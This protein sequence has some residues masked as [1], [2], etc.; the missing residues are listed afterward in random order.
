[1][2]F[3]YR[4][5]EMDQSYPLEIESFSAK[6]RIVENKL[7]VAMEE[8][9]TE[10]KLDDRLGSPK[11]SIVGPTLG[12]ASYPVSDDETRSF[13]QKTNYIDCI[14]SVL[15]KCY[16][17]C[18]CEC[19]HHC[20]RNFR[21]CLKATLI[22]CVIAAGGYLLYWLWPFFQSIYAFFPVVMIS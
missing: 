19:L 10:M 13:V 3:F 7:G 8:N 18:T 15:K 22:V 14:C 1:M 21:I 17:S 9:E 6:V 12:E 11:E 2:N 20:L 16:Y 4:L 5:M